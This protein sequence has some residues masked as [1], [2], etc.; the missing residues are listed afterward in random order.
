M[1]LTS[2]D[3]RC[4]VSDPAK[5]AFSVEESDEEAAEDETGAVIGAVLVDVEG[6]LL[7]GLDGDVAG[8]ELA[9]DEGDLLADVDGDADGD[10]LTVVAGDLLVDVTGDATGDITGDVTGDVTGEDAEPALAE[11]KIFV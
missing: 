9:D 5:H 3:S 4:R 2:P 10:V 8:A 6:D 7:A 11:Y 1:A